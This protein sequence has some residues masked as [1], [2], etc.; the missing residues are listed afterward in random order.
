MGTNSGIDVL[1]VAPSAGADLVR[2]LEQ[3]GHRVRRGATGAEAF[4]LLRCKPDL[5]I[6]DLV[7]P[8]I[9]G[10]EVL[11]HVRERLDVPVL[12]L[13]ELSSDATVVRA[14]D[15]GADDFLTSPVA[16]DVV[17][18]RVRALLRRAGAATARRHLV[19]G[20]LTVDLDCRSVTLGGRPIETTAREFDLLAFLAQSPGIVFTR[21]RLLQS[22]WQSSSSWQ[23][24]GTVTEHIRRLR[25]KIERDPRHPDWLVTVRGVGY[26]FDRRHDAGR[27]AAPPAPADAEGVERVIDARDEVVVGRAAM[28]QSLVESAQ[29]R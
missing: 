7:L 12:V 9:S 25:E 23:Q 1:L 6:L 21:E 18:A 26:R 8:V 3:D 5:V 27:A 16:A 19:H 28:P 14:L 22:V 17:A 10:L 11:V 29:C 13:T 20:Q 4:D 15:L 24:E 2:A